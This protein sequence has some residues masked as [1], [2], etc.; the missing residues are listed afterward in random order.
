MS[1]KSKGFSVWK[2]ILTTW[3]GNNSTLKYEH[4]NS[5][6]GFAFSLLSE[7]RAAKDMCLMKR[8]TCFVFLLEG[9]YGWLVLW[10]VHLKTIP[11]E[12][13]PPPL[14]PEKKE[15]GKNYISAKELKWNLWKNDVKHLFLFHKKSFQI[16]FAESLTLKNKVNEIFLH[17]W[18]FSLHS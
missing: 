1:I 16:K 10:I 13:P 3:V 4:F 17:T 14:P 18:F 9:L 8:H 15:T 7:H 2:L 11:F 6:V 5:I 12:F